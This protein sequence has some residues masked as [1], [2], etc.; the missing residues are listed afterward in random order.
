M[1]AVKLQLIT[2]RRGQIWQAEQSTLME[3]GKLS[4][5]FRALDRMADGLLCGR[6]LRSIYK[7][8]HHTVCT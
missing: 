5:D 6:T 1:A 2:E 8:K 4:P 7:F 3:S